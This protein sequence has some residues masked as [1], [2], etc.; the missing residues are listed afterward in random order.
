MLPGINFT[1]N[2]GALGL[3][4]ANIDGT[5]GLIT[6][7]V[8]IGG[9]LQLNTPYLLTSLSSLEDLGVDE[10]YDIANGT[11]LYHHCREVFRIKEAKNQT[12]ELYIYVKAMNTPM[13]D[14]ADKDLENGVTKLLQFAQGKINLLAIASVPAAT[15]P[16]V[17]ATAVYSV[18]NTLV[19]GDIIEFDVDGEI[20]A[21]H[22]VTAG[23]TQPQIAASLADSIFEPY[24]ASDS[25]ANAT[26]TGPVGSGALI[27]G[28]VINITINS[29]TDTISTIEFSGGVNPQQ[30]AP[31]LTNGIDQEVL[32]TLA[33][34]QVLAN[35]QIEEK[36]PIFVFVEGRHLFNEMVSIGALADLKALSNKNVAV[37]I[38]QDK[39]VANKSYLFAKHASVGTALGVAS[40]AQVNHSI[41]WVGQFN[42][43]S[44]GL[45]A[46][47]APA[48]SNGVL[49]ANI[50]TGALTA[51]SNKGY[52]FARTFPNLSGCYFSDSPSATSATSDYSTIENVRVVNKVVR[53]V[54]QALLPR[55]NGPILL[56][57]STGKISPDV[58]ASFEAN[59][60]SSTSDMLTNEEVSR[61]TYT[62]DP[63]Q[64]I[65]STQ[66][67]LVQ[68]R[69]LPTGKAR[70]IVVN[71]G[72]ENPLANL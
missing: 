58:A 39:V 63:N 54:Y 32:L 22:T 3:Q 65:L 61:L 19:E 27:N 36:S 66:K 8:A 24:T 20:I 70:E 7:G 48:L 64:N 45:N 52:I 11:L 33:K 57:P 47:T 72:F 25:G 16:E 23:Q 37:I 10:D 6:T 44:V 56:E 18:P 59:C 9:G 42:L 12:T 68:A 62:V 51:I 53:R 28:T 15:I 50:S 41:A 49:I 1:F 69:I 67:L 46:F 17:L 21:S 40:S 31:T 14:L 13:S 26:V 60:N 4:A 38:S 34:A 29:D 35:A 55:L 43:E 71:I 5:S 2:D 30:A